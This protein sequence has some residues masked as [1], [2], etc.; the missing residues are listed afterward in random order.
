[1]I[2]SWSSLSESKE[3]ENDMDMDVDGEEGGERQGEE[4][5]EGEGE[6]GLFM[7]ETVCYAIAAKAADFNDRLKKCLQ[8]CL[9][10]LF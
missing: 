9:Y 1:V 8:V 10:C 6:E 4:E 7:E 3:R 2:S 5:G